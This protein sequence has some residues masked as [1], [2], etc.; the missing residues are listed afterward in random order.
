MPYQ[1]TEAFR[2]GNPIVDAWEGRLNSWPLDEGLIDYVDASYGTENDENAFYAVDVIANSKISVGGKTIDVSKITPTLL[3]EV[4]HEAGGN[5]ANVATGHHAIEFLLWDQ[6]FEWE[7]GRTG[8][9]PMYAA[10]TSRR[11]P[12]L[13]R[14]RCQTVHR[15]TVRTSC[16]ISKSRHGSAGGGSG[17][18]GG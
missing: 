11:K 4:L 10:T 6:R 13:Y 1:Q 5:K 17:R 18:N 16:G 14:F 2:F 9:P 8:R 15:R 3:S 12:T 7:R